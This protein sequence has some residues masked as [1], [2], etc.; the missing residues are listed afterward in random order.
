MGSCS[1]AHS[2]HYFRVFG[3]SFDAVTGCPVTYSV[4]LL[5]IGTSSPMGLGWKLGKQY[6]YIFPGKPWQKILAITG[7]LFLKDSLRISALIVPIVIIVLLRLAQV[8]AVRVFWWSADVILLS[9][10]VVVNVS[11]PFKKKGAND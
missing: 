8:L 6:V 7:V 2:R 3:G 5:S 9:S 1:F 11:S 10:E 4:L